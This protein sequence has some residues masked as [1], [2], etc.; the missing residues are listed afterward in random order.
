MN[1]SSGWG[2]GRGSGLELVTALTVELIY[3]TRWILFMWSVRVF[4]RLSREN[5][6]KAHL[7]KAPFNLLVDVTEGP[8]SLRSIPRMPNQ[9]KPKHLQ[10]N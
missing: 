10:P 9:M 7:R 8:C 3:R 5:R 2:L 1:N 4:H 6:I